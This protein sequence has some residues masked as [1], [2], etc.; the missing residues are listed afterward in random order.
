MTNIENILKTGCEQLAISLTDMQVQQLVRYA[1]ELEKWNKTY[2]LTAVRELDAI[3]KRH[4]LDALSV[5]KSVEALAPKTLAD[6]GTG[7]GVPGVILAIVFPELRVYLVESIGKKCR[8]LRH[9][10]TVLGLASRVEVVQQR[11]EA[12]QVEAPLS[13]VICRAFTSLENFTTITRHLGDEQTTWLAMKAD[14]TDAE[15]AQLPDDF[16]ITDDVVLKVPFEDAGR[17]LL[18]LRKVADVTVG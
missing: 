7:G 4:V 3:M 10:T 8:F 9:V 13:I 15:A 14:N 12:W 18:V 11:V 17:H 2:N 5:I 6:I 16:A 1:Q